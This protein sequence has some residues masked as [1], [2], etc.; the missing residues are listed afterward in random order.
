MKLYDGNKKNLIAKT[1][2][3]FSKLTVAAALASQF[4]TQLSM[5]ARIFILLWGLGMFIL[6]CV[7]CPS[8]E[9]I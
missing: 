8:K 9:E 3:D 1:L 5:L 6:G 7:V 4:F 2:M